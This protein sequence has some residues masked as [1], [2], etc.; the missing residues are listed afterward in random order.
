MD[1]RRR[2][3]VTAV[4]WLFPIGTALIGLALASVANTESLALIVAVTALV[5]G[6]LIAVAS[7]FIG[8]R[9]NTGQAVAA[10]LP[11]IFHASAETMRETGRTVDIV[12]VLAVYCLGLAITWVIRFARGE[13][14]V[15]MLPLMVRRLLGYSAYGIVYTM[16]R[17]GPFAE[18]T[19]AWD[20]LVPFAVAV[21][22]WVA[23]EVFVRSLFVFGPRELTR[24]Y[25]ARA[26]IQDLN[27]FSGLVLTGALF[28][29]LYGP[30]G[31][32]ALPIALLPYS[33]AHAAFR[34]FQETKVTYKQTIRALARIPEVS[35][36]A[37]DGH[38]D[39]TTDLATAIAKE[40]GL[41]PTLVEQVEFAALMH[42]I[43]RISLNEPQVLKMGYTDDDIARW[44][45]EIIAESPYLAKV[46]EHVRHQYEPFRKPGQAADP[47][48]SVVSR[49]IKVAAAYDW[50]LNEPGASPLSVLES[51][52]AGVA[53][54]Y[55]PEVVAALRKVLE[56]RDRLVPAR[57]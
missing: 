18:L 43:G 25:M 10:A 56:R 32:W 37:I 5:I 8:N 6:S 39:R 29:E 38:A 20:D 17:T 51:L 54:E 12:G 23:V 31:W 36:L 24:A 16:M 3:L 40:L 35:G 4:S 14:Q 44:S 2:R 15:E 47:E 9:F 27:V 46:A 11:F 22:A 1:D 48:I 53:Y 50:K 55:D 33:F 28:G 49:I 41:G 21:I 34:R 42:D 30:L 7:S 52:H 19:G 57:A 13:D 26:F 45:A